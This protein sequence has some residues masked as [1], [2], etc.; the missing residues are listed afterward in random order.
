VRYTVARLAGENGTLAHV[1]RG[2][3][4]VGDGRAVHTLIGSTSTAEVDVLHG[5]H[6]G[7]GAALGRTG[8]HVADGLACRAGESLGAPVT[9]RELGNGSIR[10]LPVATT[11]V[12][13]R[14]GRARRS[15]LVAA[16]LVVVPGSRW[17]GRSD[18][19]TR[20]GRNA[21]LES[22]VPLVRTRAL[23]V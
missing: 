23:L 22:A 19:S 10:T 16:L 15:G 7:V 8:R 14:G 6:A 2:V 17:A 18:R 9:R 5:V 4:G 1:A 11:S 20:D 12:L 13:G 21:A 3:P